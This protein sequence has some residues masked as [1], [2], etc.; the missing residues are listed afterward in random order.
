MDKKKVL[1]GMSGGVDSSAAAAMLSEQGYEVCGCTLR[2]YDNSVL[3]EDYLEGGCCSLADVDDAKSVCRKLGI[4]HIVLNF[5]EEVGKKV[6]HPFADSYINGETP[7]PCIECNKHMKFDLM[8][9]RAELLGF[10]Y[11]ATGHYADISF[12]N[13]R[14]LLKRPADRRKDQ[15]YVLYTLTQHQLAHTPFPLYGMD[16]PAIR[17]FAE[18]RGLINSRK[19]DSQDICFVPDGDYAAFIER[20]T[21]Y[22]PAEG[23]FVDKSGEKIGVHSGIINY[24]IGQRRGLGVTFGKPVFVTEKDP[25]KGTVTLS[26]EADLFKSVLF[27]R[28]VNL[29]SLDNVSEP[30]SV[31]AKARYSAKEQEAVIFPEENGI[32]RIEFSSPVRAPAKGQA[33]V[34]YDGD[35]V[36]GGGI[37]DGAE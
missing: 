11:I 1:V 27:L 13:G 8:L 37:I 24:T 31:T 19:P 2:I 5:T 3:G 25:V 15:T 35:I 6:M 9:R 34:F 33:C 30:M 17:A 36:V 18:E 26:D 23:D 21:G 28:D 22:V 32:M 20:Y 12:E 7:N 14:Y 10:D 16:K 29:I 4:D